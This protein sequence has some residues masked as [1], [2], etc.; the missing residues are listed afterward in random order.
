MAQVAAPQGL[1]QIA[2]GRKLRGAA[3]A[4]SGM[5][6]NFARM[7]GIELIVDQRM[8]HDFCFVAGH[9]PLLLR[10]PRCTQQLARACK[11]RH[12][13]AD[14]HARNV[15]DFAIAQIVDLAQHKRL[16]KR[17]RAIA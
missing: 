16:A 15:G 1:S 11:T 2:I 12:H 13:R 10:Q 17:S 4:A 5:R 6:F 8:Q 7:P 3:R 14:R 9:E